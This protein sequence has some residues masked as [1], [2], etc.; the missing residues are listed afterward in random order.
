MRRGCLVL[1]ACLLFAPHAAAQP[2]AT[3]VTVPM[4]VKGF[5]G[6]KTVRLVATEYRPGG[7]GPFPAVVLSHG[8][9]GTPR[10]RV[11]YTAK[12]AVASAVFVRWGFVVLN[13]VRRGYGKTGGGYEEDFGRCDNPSYVEAGLETAKDIAAAVA[14]L[15]RQP[16]VDRE[17]IVLVGQSAGGWGSLAAASRGDLPVRGVV[18]FAGGRGGKQNNLPDNN[19]APDRL[20]EAAGTFG[21]TTT[22]PSLWLYTANDQFFAPE[23]SRRMHAAYAASGG[24]ATYHLLPAIGTDGHLLITFQNGVP[25]W[26][27]KVEAF[28]REIGAL[29]PR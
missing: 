24:R 14:H 25:L 21:Q 2:A 18:N 5:F 8:A 3:E 6:D 19:C 22:V 23:L 11:A 13:P 1:A 28:L 27:D 26:Q 29:S 4:T 20:V 16:F 12:F 15:R 10:E 7:S 17:R 9:P